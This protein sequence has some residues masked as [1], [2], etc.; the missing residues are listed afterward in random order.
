MATEVITT[1]DKEKRDRMFQELRSST[2]KV[3]RLI[4]GER[5]EIEVPHPQE[6]QAVKFSGVEMIAPAAVDNT[7]TP[8]TERPAQYAST[9]SV[10]YPAS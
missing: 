4:K 5:V 9:W 10:A 2:I 7:T 8:P 6:S 3:S 1:R